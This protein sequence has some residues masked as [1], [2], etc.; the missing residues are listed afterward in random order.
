MWDEGKGLEMVK[1]DETKEISYTVPEVKLC[2]E[3]SF[4]VRSLN[5][6]GPG[7]FSE[8]VKVFTSTVPKKMD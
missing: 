2:E 4:K 1:L 8:L 5:P 6:C 7:T 3:Y